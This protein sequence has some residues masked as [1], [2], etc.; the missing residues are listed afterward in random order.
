[1]GLML[2]GIGM[3][4]QAASAVADIYK[5]IDEN[6][7]VHLSDRKLNSNYKLLVRTSKSQKPRINLAGYKRNRTKFT[8][9][10]E[11]L[12]RQYQLDAD[13]VHAVVMMESAYDPRAVSSKGAVGLMQLMPGTASRYGVEDREDPEQ[14][15]RGGV[16]YLHDLL[17]QF[18]SVSLALAAYNAGEN[19]VIRY[20][21]QIPP[22][23]E[24]QR[25]VWKVLSHYRELKSAT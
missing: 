17:L 13:L 1:M 4:L 11:K 21:R 20:G 12:A 23:P 19:A 18:R 8:P 2:L 15:V 10:I 6:G 7:M 25:Y 5:W 16:R 3:M 9:M 22:Y 24:T 14:N